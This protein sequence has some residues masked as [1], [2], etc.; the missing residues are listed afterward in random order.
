M[1]VRFVACNRAST[2]VLVP[3]AMGTP[4][5]TQMLGTQAEQLAELAGRIC[6]DSLG[7]GRSSAEYHEHIVAVGHLSVYEHCVFTVCVRAVTNPCWYVALLNRPGV[8]VRL[9]EPYFEGDGSRL[10]SDLR[11]TL[12]L[13]SVL[14]WDMWSAIWHPDLLPACGVLG[15][16]L[17][18]HAHE[19]APQVV[20][21]PESSELCSNLIR[22]THR[23][24]PTNQDELWVTLYMA[25]SRSWSHEMVRHGDFTAVSQRSTRYCDEA[26]SPHVEHPGIAALK[27]RRRTRADDY[28]VIDVVEAYIHNARKF[29]RRAYGGIAS[30]LQS[31]LGYDKKSAR[32]AAATLL[33]HDTQTELLFTASARQWLNIAAQR[34][35]KSANAEIRN[36][37]A[38]AKRVVRSALG[39]LS[40]EE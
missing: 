6:Y 29:S 36:I 8:S 11:V 33:T 37:I 1:T 26:D 13:R 21:A 19:I 17:R 38:D 39:H 23:I 35:H 5:A 31:E 18:A 16:L 24:D 3:P 10:R 4:K 9:I 28:D 32:G 7:Q 22:M 40:T 20:S 15:D 30:L 27:A 12:N 25:G 14:E 34:T 2:E